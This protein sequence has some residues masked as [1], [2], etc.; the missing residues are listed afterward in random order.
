[1]KLVYILNQRFPTEKAYGI[2]VIQMCAAF[3][4]SGLETEL[5]VPT[6]IGRELSDPFV[7]YG[8]E[9]SFKFT[10]VSSLDWYWPSGLNRVAF[11]IKNL[12]SAFRLARIAR[13]RPADI[14]YARE[15]LPLLF[16]VFGRRG[17]LALEVHRYSSG[18]AFMY[19][20]LSRRGVRFVAVTE[21]LRQDLI[22]TGIPATSIFT[23]HD[24][25]E[26]EKFEI[27]IEQAEARRQLNL[28]GDKKIILYS[29]HLYERKGADTLAESTQF[30]PADILNVFV[31]GTDRELELFKK[32][33]GD[34]PKIMI[35]GRK[36][37]RQI[38]LWLRAAD[39]L[40]LP[41]LPDES[42]Q[43]KYTSPL[44]LFEY[45]A[46]GRPIIASDLPAVREVLSDDNAD[47]YPPGDVVALANEIKAVLSDLPRAEEKA[48]HAKHKVKTYSWKN[49]ADNIISFL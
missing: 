32:Q 14:I 11:W 42:G 4:K 15:E 39:V 7:Y 47:F 12:T 5:L 13:S 34:E 24:G 36:P 23:A 6:R 49:R 1:M 8:I 9:P 38:P 25:V 30:L 35:T 22:G 45:M 29:G 17:K 44:K 40:V 48:L 46:S 10:M 16:L 3:S 20:F 19:H 2:Q 43:E 26:I 33:W 27:N 21:G 28:P 31:G 37:H 41:S 18:R